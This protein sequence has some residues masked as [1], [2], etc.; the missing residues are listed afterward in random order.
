MIFLS[1]DCRGLSNSS[2][3]LAL[4]YL[5]MKSVCDVIMLQETLCSGVSAMNIPGHMMLGWSFVALDARG[6]S[7]G[8]YKRKHIETFKFLGF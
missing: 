1:F 7:G 8:G 2:K 3:R 6:R 4:K 5:F